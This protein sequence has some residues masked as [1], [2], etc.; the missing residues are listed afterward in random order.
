M[1]K[2][3]VET[4]CTYRMRYVVEAEDALEAENYVMDGLQT[5]NV[6]EFSQKHIGEEVFSVHKIKNG[7]YIKLFDTDNDYLQ[8]WP[9]H[10]KKEFINKQEDMPKAS[11]SLDW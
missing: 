3:L 1:K 6:K 4:V 9:E 5:N 7:D 10:M 8:G 11:Q 2:Y